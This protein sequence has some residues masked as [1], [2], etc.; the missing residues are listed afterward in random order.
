ML[1]VG[2][3]LTV[4]GWPLGQSLAVQDIRSVQA[5][6]FVGVATPVTT[7]RTVAR[8]LVRHA[9]RQTLG[10]FLDQPAASVALVSRPGEALAVDSSPVPLGLSLSHAP[11]LSIA[12]ICRGA[13]VGI[14]V[15][16]LQVGVEA[17]PDWA[18]V[19][20]DYLGPQV[21]TVLHATSA[22]ERAVAFVTAWTRFEACLKCLGLALTEW[23]PALEKLLATCQV[24]TLD[25]A[26]NLSGSP[27]VDGIFLGSVAVRRQSVRPA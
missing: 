22:A 1:P 15:M 20:R 12:A 14:D 3:V 17:N 8:T 27:A 2:Q 26:E 16:H 24:S 11:G 4:R 19:A 5:V 13:G 9:V 10:E 6:A 18:H 25:F 21:T 7:D 23:S